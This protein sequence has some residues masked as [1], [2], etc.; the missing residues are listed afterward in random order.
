[1]AEER[2]I[3]GRMKTVILCRAECQ[4]VISETAIGD[5]HDFLSGQLWLFSLRHLSTPK[6]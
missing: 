3:Q 6:S 2:C 4:M 1:M 5:I